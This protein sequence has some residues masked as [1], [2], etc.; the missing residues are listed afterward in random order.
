MKTNE[1]ERI[2]ITGMPISDLA[3]IY[4]E[5]EVYIERLG[6]R[7]YLVRTNVKKSNKPEVEI[8]LETAKEILEE[9]GI[10]YIAIFP[11]ENTPTQFG[12]ALRYEFKFSFLEDGL[13]KEQ[14]INIYTLTDE[15]KTERNKLIEG[16]DLDKNLYYEILDKE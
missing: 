5:Y 4:S 15:E 1:A 7:V 2:D 11:L 10:K 14:Y 12:G 8:M 16:I 3:K 13:A 9:N 6:D